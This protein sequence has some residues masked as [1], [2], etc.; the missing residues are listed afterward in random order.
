MDVPMVGLV[1][2]SV[3]DVADWYTTARAPQCS[4]NNPSLRELLDQV[5]RS[6]LEGQRETTIDLVNRIYWLFDEPKPMRS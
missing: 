4:S 1:A 5:D 6:A 3:E 2:Q